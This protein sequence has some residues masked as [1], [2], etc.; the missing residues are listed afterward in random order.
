MHTHMTHSA[1]GFGN[2][3]R[4]DYGTGHELKFVAFLCCLMKM[5]VIP[6]DNAAAV[7]VHVISK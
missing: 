1:E 5:N 4:I 7:V 2:V 3:T 6:Q